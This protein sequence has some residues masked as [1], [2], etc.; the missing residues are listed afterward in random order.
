MANRSFEQMFDRAVRPLADK[1]FSLKEEHQISIKQLVQVE[2]LLALSSTGFCRSLIFQTKNKSCLILIICPLQ[3]IVHD[4]IRD[5]SPTGLSAAQLSDY[6]SSFPK[7]IISLSRRDPHLFH[8]LVCEQYN[9]QP[10]VKIAHV[11][12]GAQLA[13]KYIIR[14]SS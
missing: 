12:R 10:E 9:L 13:R 4:Q 5:A 3:S 11:P 8:R 14:G 1:G 7:S 6:T 2:D